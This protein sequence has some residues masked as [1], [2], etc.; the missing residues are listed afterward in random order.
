MKY[1]ALIAAVFAIQKRNNGLGVSHLSSDDTTTNNP[2]LEHEYPVDYFDHNNI[3]GEAV[4]GTNHF[5]T[6]PRGDNPNTSAGF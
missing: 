2:Q 6:V 1:F 4:L 5:G 3:N